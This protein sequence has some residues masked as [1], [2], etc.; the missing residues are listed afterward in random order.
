M[1]I[2]F[3]NFSRLCDFYVGLSGMFQVSPPHSTGV[4]SDMTKEQ[5]EDLFIEWGPY[6]PRGQRSMIDKYSTHISKE[7][8]SK[9]RFLD[10]FKDKPGVEGYW[11]KTGLA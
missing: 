10:F 2:L 5:Q 7:D 6:D 8:C 3:V 11:E 1:V 4:G 9:S